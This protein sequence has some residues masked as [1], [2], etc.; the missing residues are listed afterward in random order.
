MWSTN[1]HIPSIPEKIVAGEDDPRRTSCCSKA[2]FICYHK[3][4][5][6]SLEQG[7]MWQ[8]MGTRKLAAWIDWVIQW[9]WSVGQSCAVWQTWHVFGRHCLQSSER[10]AGYIW[11]RKEASLVKPKIPNSNKK[12]IIICIWFYSLQRAYSSVISCNFT[13][14]PMRQEL[15]LQL[16]DEKMKAERNDVFCPKLHRL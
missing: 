14:N 5:F 13:N 9:K 10:I 6:G 4:L 2:I 16:T 15:H 8:E 12:I 11:G 7:W 3:P 1:R